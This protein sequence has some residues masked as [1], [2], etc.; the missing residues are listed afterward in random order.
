MSGDP[1]KLVKFVCVAKP[2]A[3]GRSDAAL[4][5]HQGVWAFCPMG[6][7]QTGHDW[8]A[9]DG[10]PLTDALRFAPRHLAPEPMPMAPAQPAKPTAPAVGRSRAR[11]R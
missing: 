10:L 9:S 3:A 8:Q 5:I 4:T 11:P 2:H 6:T 7:G 1:M